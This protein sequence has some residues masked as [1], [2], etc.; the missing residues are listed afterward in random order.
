MRTLDTVATVPHAAKW[1]H[2]SQGRL[3]FFGFGRGGQPRDFSRFTVN[4]PPLGAALS[5]SSLLDELPERR[6]RT[7][8]LV[9]G[10]WRLCFVRPQRDWA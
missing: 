2:P 10:A 4:I 3:K 6:H 7:V 9:S 5:T 8:I 1:Q